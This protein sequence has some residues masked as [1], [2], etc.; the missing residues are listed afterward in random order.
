[1]KKTSYTQRVD[2]GN[3]KFGGHVRITIEGPER[4]GKTTL[5]EVIYAALKPLYSNISRPLEDGNDLSFKTSTKKLSYTELS[6]A[7]K[8]VKF[9]DRILSLTINVK[10]PKQKQTDPKDRLRKKL[11]E[12][13]YTSREIAIALE[14]YDFARRAK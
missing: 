13:G 4:T 10:N 1:M 9:F 11:S 6:K 14:G 5:A 12:E 8:K 7:I 3:G 2:L